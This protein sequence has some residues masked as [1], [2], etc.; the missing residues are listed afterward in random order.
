VEKWIEDAVE[1]YQEKLLTGNKSWPRLLRECIA[2]HAPKPVMPEPPQP[3]AAPTPTRGETVAEEQI[4]TKNGLVF[5]RDADGIAH[6]AFMHSNAVDAVRSIVKVFAAAID[7]ERRDA[8]TE[9]AEAMRQRCAAE[10]DRQGCTTLG[11]YIR[12]LGVKD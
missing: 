3:A 8:A 11:K 4:T 12:A 6:V 2:S 1:D 5:I 7:A 9:A 10:M